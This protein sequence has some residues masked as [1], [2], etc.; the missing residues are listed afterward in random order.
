MLSAGLLHGLAHGPQL[1]S[2]GVR[3]E[4]GQQQAAEEEEDGAVAGTAGRLH[5]GHADGLHVEIQDHHGKDDHGEGQ[6]EAGP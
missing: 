4:V 6:D 1:V 2:Q 3:P 5:L